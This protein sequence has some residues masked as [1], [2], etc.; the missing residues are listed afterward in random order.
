MLCG[1]VPLVTRVAGLMLTLWSQQVV[2]GT[3]GSK[4]HALPHWTV[5]V[6]LQVRA[7]LGAGAVTWNGSTHELLVAPA[8]PQ[9]VTVMGY[10]RSEEHTSELQSLRHL[11]CR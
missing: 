9:T 3:G 4:S 2:T 7:R 5:L 8:Q 10:T 1:Q 11:V 6:G